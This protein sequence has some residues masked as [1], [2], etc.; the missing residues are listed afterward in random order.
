MYVQYIFHVSCD[1]LQS[2][3]MFDLLLGSDPESR[4]HQHDGSGQAMQVD[5][6]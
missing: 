6:T 3:L 4:T 1:N 2:T 5:F